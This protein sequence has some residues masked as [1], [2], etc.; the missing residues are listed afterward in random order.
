MA[1]DTRILTDQMVL[2]HTREV[3]NTHL[4]L[5]ADG[6]QC[7]TADLIDCLVGVT[8]HASSLQA[9]G[10]ARGGA[11]TGHGARL[12]QRSTEPGGVAGPPARGERRPGQPTPGARAHPAG[13]R[14]DRSARPTLLR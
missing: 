1:H 10:S 6:S 13:G 12:S 9:L 7:T 4:T 2:D 8:A 5:Q 14:S 11:A 3:L